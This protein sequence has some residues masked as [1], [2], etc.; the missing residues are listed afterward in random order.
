M[1][2]D[3]I[4]KIIPHRE[5]F[6]LVDEVT[7][8]KK[9]EVAKG[10]KKVRIDEPWFKGHFPDYPIM[11][12][13]LTVESIAQLGAICLMEG[14]EL[15]ILGKIERFFFKRPVFPGD[16]LELEVNVVWKRK[17]IAKI[18]GVARV[19]EE[20]VGEGDILAAIKKEKELRR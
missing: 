1:T 2:K 6:L 14:E 10:L 13:V 5:P 8:I 3:K 11:P 17:N 12:G 4:K 15:P 20:I 16:T 7:F 9:G 19:K 18:H